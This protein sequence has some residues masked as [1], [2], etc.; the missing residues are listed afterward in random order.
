MGNRK[1][2][3]EE[4]LGLRLQQLGRAPLIFFLAHLLLFFFTPIWMWGGSEF[5]SKWK[6]KKFTFLGVGSGSGA[7]AMVSLQRLIFPSVANLPSDCPP[8]SSLIRVVA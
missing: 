6:R 8:S 7:A 3:I 4:V 2:V 1:G 5:N